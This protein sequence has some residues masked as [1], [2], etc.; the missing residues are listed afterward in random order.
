MNTECRIRHSKLGIRHSQGFLAFWTAVASRRTQ[1]PDIR[2]PFFHL[3]GDGCWTPLDD[4]GQPT[5]ERRRAVVARLDADF[6]DCLHDPA[7]R[8]LP[9]S[10]EPKVNQLAAK[11][12]ARL[13][14]DS[15]K[16]NI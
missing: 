10:E 12:K 6:F 1:R 4:A 3:H 16:D 7:F 8:K 11:M 15:K 2:L 9:R 14:C 13:M 5:T